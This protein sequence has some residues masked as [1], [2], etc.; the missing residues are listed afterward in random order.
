VKPGKVIGRVVATEKYSDLEGERFLIVQPTDWEFHDRGDPLIATD[1]VGSGAGEKV[2]YVESREAG[3]A[4]GDPVPSTD[5][6]V[7]G[8]I[9]DVDLET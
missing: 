1:S 8:I 4:L 3:I 2:I 9:D 6:S 7:C 5:A